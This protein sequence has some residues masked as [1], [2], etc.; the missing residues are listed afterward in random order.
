MTRQRSGKFLPQKY[1]DGNKFCVGKSIRKCLDVLPTSQ[2]TPLGGRL[3]FL[4][5]RQGLTQSGLSRRTGISPATICKLERGGET[6]HPEIVGK[7]LAYFGR[8]VMEAFP[9]GT[10]AVNEL[11]PVKDFGSW[12]RNLR[13]RQGLQQAELAEM[14]GVSKASMSAY[15]Q[16]QTKPRNGVLKRLRKVLKLNREFDRFL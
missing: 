9:E 7:L 1:L 4:R 11:I 13:V 8:D 14:L 6:T 3:R 2:N 12:L 5:K 15:E 16:N 10:D